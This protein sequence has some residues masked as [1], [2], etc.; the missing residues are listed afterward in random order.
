MN[1]RIVQAARAPHFPR[2][3][4]RCKDPADRLLTTPAAN[5][6]KPLCHC[7]ALPPAQ[8]RAS[9]LRTAFFHTAAVMAYRETAPY[10]PQDPHRIQQLVQTLEAHKGKSKKDSFSCRKHDFPLGGGRS[11][12]SWKIP[13]WDYKKENL[14]TYARGLFTYKTLDGRSEIAVRGYDKFFNCDEVRKTQWPNIERHTRGPYELSVKENGCIIFIAGL[15]DDSLLVCSKH[16]TGERPDGQSHACVGE[17]WVERHLATVGRTKSDLARRLREMNATLVAELCDDDF[18]EHVLPY[19]PEDAGLYIHGI[20]LN[21]P[22]F[23]TY[24]GPLVD[25]FAD[26]WGMKKVIYVMKDDIKDV[27]TFLEKVAETGSYDGHH[28][29]GFVIRCQTR[30]SD[31]A[32]WE[33]WFFKYKFEEPYL[34]YRQWRECT[35]DIIDGKTPRIKKHKAITQEYL[36]FARKTFVQ[37]PGLAKLY[38]HNHGIIALRDNFLKARGTTGAEVIQQELQN[39]EQ[40]NS[41][42]TRN[43]VLVPV[44]TIGCGK[45]TLALALV[46]LFGWGHFQNDNVKAKQFRGKVFADTISSL[47]ISNP[48]VIADRNNHQKRER[49]QLFADMAKIPNIHFVALHYVHDRANYDAIR[50]ATQARVLDRGDNHQTIQAGSKDKGEILGIMEGFMGRFQPL[51]P[52][53][54]P[55]D[56]FDHVINLDPVA[57]SR[58]NLEQIISSLYETYPGLFKDREMPSANEMDDAINWALKDYTPDFKMDLSRGATNRGATNRGATNRGATNRG[59]TKQPRMEYFSVQLNTQRI[60]SILDATFNGR[61][62]EEAQL[63][64]QLDQTRRVQLKFH[65]T[66]MHRASASENQQYWNKLNSLHSVVSASSSDN[67]EPELGKCDVQLERLIWD[68]RI[69]C[70]VVR[71]NGSATLQL[72][73]EAGSGTE[74]LIFES[75]NPVAHITVGTVDQSVKPR[76]SNDLLQRWLNEGS[77]GQTGIWEAP[78][79]GNG[80][81]DGSVRVVRGRM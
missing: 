66:L 21:L 44:A 48:V 70:F 63:Y 60:K 14:P 38:I 29:E 22:E 34:M 68:D 39:S 3:C 80:M 57:D 71:L 81:L 5:N 79:K 15:D 53:E 52:S 32:P 61:K 16:S 30:Q 41:Y 25:K 37:Q 19:K 47:L 28:T 56:N 42:V 64:R 58:E 75:V 31:D 10:A 54:A 65:V 17:K 18:E 59:A 23:A 4:V 62:P 74:K 45:T 2:P 36:D 33:D 12:A 77:G 24:P 7:R 1:A 73:S 40:G 55:D 8:Q 51:D 46:K 43:V 49:D 26:E 67:L 76:E 11:V 13:E 72:Q 50:H 35:K 20:N 27:R 69:M 9:P 78:I 6:S